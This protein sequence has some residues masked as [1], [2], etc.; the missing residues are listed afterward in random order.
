MGDLSSLNS[1]SC[2]A[3]EGFLVSNGLDNDLQLFL[4]ILKMTAPRIFLCAEKFAGLASF[5]PWEVHP[6]SQRVG[7]RE[8]S[9]ILT[10]E[11]IDLSSLS[12][13]TRECLMRFPKC[14]WPPEAWNL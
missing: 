6:N 7:T 3:E 4:V 12:C 5:R 13:D 11:G 1:D 8:C 14:L 10:P 9:E 2:I